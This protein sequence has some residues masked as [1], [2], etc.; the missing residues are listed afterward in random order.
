MVDARNPRCGIKVDVGLGTQNI[1]RAVDAGATM[2]VVGSSTFKADD[3]SD[4]LRN[5]R[6]RIDAER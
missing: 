1:E 6:R 5:M 4:A 3:P 2:L